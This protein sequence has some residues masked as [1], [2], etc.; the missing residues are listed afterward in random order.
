M[1]AS[2]AQSDQRSLEPEGPQS[3]AS[4]LRTLEKTRLINQ[5][6]L[7]A[8]QEGNLESLGSTDLQELSVRIL[9]TLSLQNRWMITT[10]STRA[11]SEDAL[12]QQLKTIGLEQNKLDP[13]IF[14][15]DELL[16]LV[17]E[18]A[19]LI[20]GTQLQQECFFSELSALA[21]L[22]PVE[23]LTQETPLSFANKTLEYQEVSNN[24]SLSV[25]R[26]FYLELLKRYDLEE[27]EPTQSLDKEELIQQ[28]PS[29]H[30]LALEEDR[31]ELYKQTIG[32]LIW[33]S[34]ACRPDISFEAHL[35]AQSLEAPT[36]GDEDQLLRVLRYLRNTLH[37][38]V[39]LHPTK[40]RKKTEEPQLKLVAF[41][42]TSWTGAFGA[43]GTAYLSLWGA[44]LMTSCKTSS[45]QNQEQ[46]ELDGVKLALAMASYTKSFLQQLDQDELGKEVHISLRTTS[47]NQKPE[48]GRPLA[49]QLGLSRRNRHIQ[50]GGQLRLSK[51]HPSKNLAHSL[52]HIA[53]E[54][55]MLAKLKMNTEASKILALS[56]VR[57][58]GIACLSSSS[59]LLVGMVSVV[60]PPM[61]SQLRQLA[62]PT[63]SCDKSLLKTLQ[64]LT[65]ESLSLD[66]REGDS[67]TVQSLSFTRGI[68]ESLTLESLSRIRDRL[69]SLTW[70]SLSLQRID[71][72]SLT[73]QSLSLNEDT[74]QSNSFP[75]DSLDQENLAHTLG[76]RTG[77]NSFSSHRFEKDQLTRK[78]A[79]T[80]SLLHLS[81]QKRILSLRL[82]SLIFLFWSF[83]LVCAALLLKHCYLTRILPI[84]SLQPDQLVA[85]YSTM[86]FQDSFQKK[87]LC[88]KSFDSNHLCRTQLGK[89]TLGSFQLDHGHSLSFPGFSQNSSRSKPQPVSLNQLDLDMS[90]SFLWFNS[91]S[92]SNQ[93]QAESF[94]RNRINTERQTRQV[95]SFQLLIQQF[96]LDQVSGGVLRAFHQP[97][98]Q[99]R[100]L[101]A[102]WTLMSLSLV[103]NAWL[104]TS[105][106][107]AWRRRS[108]RQRLLTACTLSSLSLALDALVTPSSL[109][110][111]KT[112]SSRISLCR[113][114]WSTTVSTSAFTN[115]APRPT[116][117]FPTTSFRSLA[118]TRASSPSAFLPTSSLRA[119]SFRR[120]ASMRH[121]QPT[122]FRSTLLSIFLVS[123]MVHNF[124]FNNIFESCPLGLLHGHLGQETQSLDQLSDHNLME[125]NKKEKK[126][127][128]Q[129][130]LSEAMPDKELAQLQLSQLRACQLHLPDQPFRG[131][132]QLP[133]E[134]SFTSCPLR[135]MISSFFQKKLERL[136]LTRS[137]LSQNLS[138][139]QLGFNQFLAENFGNQLSEQ[140]LQQNLST[141]QRQL[142]NSKLNQQTL[143]Q[144][145]LEHP[146]L[147]ETILHKELATIF[148]KNSFKDNLVFQNLC[149]TTLA[150]QKVASEH[151][152]ENNLDKKQLPENNLYK[153]QLE[154]NN[155]PQTEEACKEQL[156]RT[157]F[158]RASLDQQLFS[159]SLVQQSGAKAASHQEL[160][161]RELPGEELADRNFDK[162]TLAPSLPTTTSARQLQ[163]NQLEE[164]T[165]T[166]NSFEA[167]CLSSFKALCLNSFPEPACKEELLP[168]QL[169]QQQ[170]SSRPFQ[171]DSLLTSSLPGESF[172]TGTFSDSSFQ[173]Q[174]FNTGTFQSTAWST[175]PSAR[176]LPTQ[177]LDR[178][179]FQQQQLG[180]NNFQ[181]R[182]FKK[183]NLDT[184]T[185]EKKS[186]EENLTKNSFAE[187]SFATKSFAE[188]SLAAKNFEK[189]F[190]K[191]SFDKKSF[192]KKSFD[193]KS[194][195]FEKSF[196]EKSLA[197]KSLPE[198]SFDQSSLAQ[199]SFLES[200][201]EA[202]S[203]A[204]SSLE[205][206]SFA[207]TSFAE[208]S[209]KEATFQEESF[210]KHSLEES[211][212]TEETFHHASL[213]KDAF[214]KS[215]FHKSSLE[216]SSFD[217]SSFQE[218]S[219]DESSFPLSSF[220]QKSF[221]KSSFTK[222]FEES[223]FSQSSLT[224]SSFQQ[225]S[226]QHSSSEDNSF[227]AQS[228][229]RS[230]LREHSF[231]KK[232]STATSF[233]ESSLHNNSFRQHSFR[234]D[235][236]Q[237][238]S[239]QQTSIR[240]RSLP[241]ELSPLESQTFQEQLCTAHFSFLLGK[242][243]GLHCWQGALHCACQRGS[244]KIPSFPLAQLDLISLS[245]T[246][247]V[248]Q[249]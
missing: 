75:E 137:S 123:F 219:L 37:S 207:D 136:H 66:R 168:D 132:K 78:E 3:A 120:S 198:K 216:E 11:S 236:F 224:A 116:W 69:C 82:C 151:L 49:R 50:L 13:N 70:H 193:K 94:C 161:R 122:S 65:F 182:S 114:P 25:P 134:Q 1:K 89:S 170:L 16:I 98:L 238:Q 43:I 45:A 56:T 100:V 171:Q 81:L 246:L 210:Q 47:W 31:H 64:S 19:L 126:T 239:F 80:N 103:M 76:K 241:T 133:E 242:S 28:E 93:P 110:A 62:C 172:R 245:L 162:K 21:S 61:A 158:P 42:S 197:E 35:L 17:H 195:D 231:H 30:S 85:A 160:L 240:T 119:T 128:K 99:T 187:K 150:L 227:K 220:T 63:K 247:L 196:A 54:Q 179:N 184:N 5:L 249:A 189:S 125:K 228:L 208:D 57:C 40:P 79:K 215:S 229:L 29:E 176:Q 41:S 218:S 102:A 155:F 222:S 115:L 233:Q 186:F 91:I 77:T 112:T 141:D 83:Q 199:S 191:K 117:S 163:K 248:A 237:Q 232:S 244:A 156:L 26:A 74:F 9:L 181:D 27:V 24:I 22:E 46:A 230:S 148:A 206:K 192:D 38:C 68:L 96:C 97:A 2:Q 84:Q 212:L 87:K 73:L 217:K 59:S 139:N 135:Q 183:D 124:F 48:L 118:S 60:P 214:N 58:P 166:E 32:D 106:N 173:Q 51:V 178:R 144:L 234:Q 149:L 226:F 205:E 105:S 164:E 194:F 221:D 143:Q 167:L 138:Q 12:G 146:N 142:Q 204:A 165:F 53:P 127:K 36:T 52:S 169:L 131:R 175:G 225:P 223:S 203:F 86:S 23:K 109:R 39:S 130:Q 211:S 140:Q 6:E 20:G 90:L 152:G 8:E 18:S 55:M 174:S 92:F 107:T 177:Q 190:D 71:S 10:L 44:C 154:D 101:I 33:L 15:G 4:Q 188:Q 111:L 159:N 157:G 72:Q 180:R 14:A 209:F 88:N 213:E 145:S 104:K 113:R 202:S 95:Q 67:L 7:A 121:V 108:F 243:L 129:H 34:N 185:F 235:S 147:T 153:K 200:S 201:F